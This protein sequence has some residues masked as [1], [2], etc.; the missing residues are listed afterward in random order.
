MDHV[1]QN[2]ASAEHRDGDGSRSYCRN[3]RNILG[4]A[5]HMKSKQCV[6]I[7]VLNE[8]ARS[9]IVHAR[10][11][12][13][14]EV[15]SPACSPRV[16]GVS[17]A[18]SAMQP[19]DVHGLQT[20]S[21]NDLGHHIAPC[22]EW[23]ESSKFSSRSSSRIAVTWPSRSRSE[24]SRAPCARHAGGQTIPAAPGNGLEARRLSS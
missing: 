18:S 19:I 23:I 7:M 12:D 5:T 15:P 4:S 14:Q 20:L 2:E 22:R 6:D 16:V 8:S 24:E 11:I 21:A 1:S 9:K 3:H 17:S 10:C 13:K